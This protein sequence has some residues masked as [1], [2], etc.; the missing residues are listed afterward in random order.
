M[1]H[2]EMRAF[3]AAEADTVAHWIGSPQDAWHI[4][5]LEDWPIASH[6]IVQWTMETNLAFT[7]RRDG[8]LAAY[9]EILED[10]VE[11]DA[12]IQHLLVAP[13]MRGQGIGQAMLS[14]LI[15][16]LAATRPYP[17]VWMR[18]GRD[19]QPAQ[20]CARA[21]GFEADTSMSGPRY[22]WM[23]KSLKS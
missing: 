18:I 11:G 5:G 10:E 23:K 15:A 17:I 21:S 3:A 16:V 22:L 13:D 20:L 4:A 6:Q 8:D 19:N 7:L 2:F 1:P 14:R 12:E 9:G